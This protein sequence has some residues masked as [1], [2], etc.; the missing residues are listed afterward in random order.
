MQ[1]EMNTAERLHME[2]LTRA[3]DV[4]RSWGHPMPTNGQIAQ[5]S[6]ALMDDRCRRGHRVDQ[7]C[8]PDCETYESHELHRS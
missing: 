8:T 5:L 6:R 3:L 2:R 4:I 1:P 7:T